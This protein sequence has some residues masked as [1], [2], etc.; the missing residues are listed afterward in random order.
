[1]HIGSRT[2]RFGTWNE[3]LIVWWKYSKEEKKAN[4]AKHALR[5]KN[6]HISQPHTRIVQLFDV[7]QWMVAL[8]ALSLRFVEHHY[9]GRQCS[10]YLASHDPPIVKRR[11]M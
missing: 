3:T 11:Q 1:M 6:L 2:V 5:E 9:A 4:Y 10:K 8:S 7:F